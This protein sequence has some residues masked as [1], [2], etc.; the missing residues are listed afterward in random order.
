MKKFFI[1]LNAIFIYIVTFG[2][3]VQNKIDFSSVD[4]S[5]QLMN[6]LKQGIEST[7]EEWI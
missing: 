6:R 1:F 2:Q 7:N 5:F 3:T 4:E